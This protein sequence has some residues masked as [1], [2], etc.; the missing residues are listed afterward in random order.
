MLN[1]FMLA[2]GRLVQQE[3][4]NP[5]DLAQ[6]H[7]PNEFIPVADMVIATKAIALTLLAWCGYEEAR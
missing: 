4:D 2:Q 3:I 5:G 7:S 6:A 1:V